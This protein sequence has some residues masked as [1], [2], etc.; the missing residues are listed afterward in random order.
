MFNFIIFLMGF[1]YGMLVG[2]AL[3]SLYVLNKKKGDKMKSKLDKLLIK[4]NKITK[5]IIKEMNKNKKKVKSLD[6]NIN[7]YIFIDNIIYDIDQ[8]IPHID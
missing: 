7:K 3:I 6:K 1:F 8:H 2:M 4:R 5:D